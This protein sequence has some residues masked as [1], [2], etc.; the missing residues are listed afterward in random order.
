MWSQ[1]DAVTDLPNIATVMNPSSGESS[2]VSLDHV[3]FEFSPLELGPWHQ[4]EDTN[5]ETIFHN[6]AYVERQADSF[7]MWRMTRTL[8]HG[9]QRLNGPYVYR[10]DQ[11]S[12]HFLVSTDRRTWIDAE[13]DPARL[14]TLLV[15]LNILRP[16]SETPI[17]D[18]CAFGLA[19]DHIRSV[20]RVGGA[21]LRRASFDG[22][23]VYLL[24][25]PESDEIYSKNL[26]LG[27]MIEF[28]Q[29]RDS[30]ASRVTNPD[31]P[32]PQPQSG[33]R[34]RLADS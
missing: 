32:V 6:G 21:Q 19:D 9:P 23:E 24:R 2:T 15:C 13:N 14:K 8:P 10:F 26:K 34:R 18:A 30:P 20:A 5:S 7:L 25:H 27:T 11:D 12:A 17:L 16:L 3:Y 1:A 31:G 4:V 28:L 22:E 29:E 33:S